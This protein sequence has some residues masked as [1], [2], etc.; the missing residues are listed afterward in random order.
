MLK[1]KKIAVIGGGKMG[2]IIAQALLEKRLCLKK[3][4]IVTD[5]DSN[6]LGF[7]ASTMG[8]LVS[9]DNK[10]ATKNADIIIV[11]VKPQNM[12]ETLQDISPV[13]NESKI[14]ISI[15]AGITTSFIESFLLKGTR[16][17]RVMPNTPAMVGEGATAVAKGVYATTGDL[18]MTRAIFDALG[19]SFEVEE[20]YMDAVTGLSGSGP[21]YFFMI[22]EALIDAGEKVGL[23]RDLAAK[24]S[25]QTMLGAARLCLQSDKSPSELREMVTSP[26]GTTAAGLKVLR[27][28]KLRETLLAAV[29]AATKRSKDLAAGK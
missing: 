24:L 25:A 11:A 19:L 27:E 17:L 12:K 16:V 28:G 18:T 3:S 1:G 26:S 10:Q 14:I 22:I 8:I 13:V 20:K 21:A 4:V 2:S 7:L 9:S 5:V 23:A 29:E 6:R 15:A